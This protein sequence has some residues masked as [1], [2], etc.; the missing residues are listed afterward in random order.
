MIRKKH[1]GMNRASTFEENADIREIRSGGSDAR[2][3]DGQTE[4]VRIRA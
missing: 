2:D 1:K 3:G 4:G